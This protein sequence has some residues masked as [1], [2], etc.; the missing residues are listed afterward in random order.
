MK[1]ETIVRKDELDGVSNWIWPKD[2]TGLWNGPAD[3]WMKAKPIIQE[4]CRGFRTVVQAGGG[5]GM[6]PRL[7]SQM[8]EKVY[9][10]EPDGYNFHCLVQNCPSDHIYKFNAALS[11]KQQTLD[12]HG[13]DPTNRGTGTIN[14][15]NSSKDN[16]GNI[17]ALRIDDFV[18]D[19]LDFIYLDVE[20][21]ETNVIYGAMNNIRKH[22][23]LIACETEVGILS[24]L[25]DYGYIIVAKGGFD[26]FFKCMDEV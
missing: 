19:K 13:C 3:D 21:W 10:F 15:N 2:D 5:C 25:Q 12:M 23:P 7:L 4:H 26:T 16:S 22:K 18:F 20:R 24:I 17:P 1:Y 11:D 6:Y 14:L 9:T 8:F